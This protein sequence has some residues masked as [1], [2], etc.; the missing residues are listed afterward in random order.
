MKVVFFFANGIEVP[1]ADSLEKLGVE[2]RGDRIWK[3]ERLE[4][5]EDSSG[6]DSEEIFCLAENNDGSYQ[7]CIEIGQYLINNGID[8]R[9]RYVPID[10]CFLVCL[11]IS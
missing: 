10:F 5:E 6:S 9:S 1:L 7:N 8:D 2:V 11:D 3:V 4:E